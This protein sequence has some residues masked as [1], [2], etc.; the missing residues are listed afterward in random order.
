MSNH[1]L[2][3]EHNSGSCTI[4]DHFQL[5]SLHWKSIKEIQKALKFF[6]Y[7]TKNC[8]C[9]LTFLDC[10]I[11]YISLKQIYG[12][13]CLFLQLT[14]CKCTTWNWLLSSLITITLN[15]LISSWALQLMVCFLRAPKAPLRTSLSRFQVNASLRSVSE[16]MSLKAEPFTTN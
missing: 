13:G 4:V 5:K 2:E 8:S 6:F 14:M 3:P 15:K 9:L 7:L 1:K 16:A 12:N 10:R 11:T